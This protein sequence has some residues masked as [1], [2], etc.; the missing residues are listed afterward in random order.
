MSSPQ[1]IDHTHDDLFLQRLSTQLNP[2][3][4]LLI[5]G[6]QISWSALETHFGDLYVSERGHP[7]KPIRLMCGLLMLQHLEG[8]SD[9]AVVS[10]WVEN[11]YWQLFCGY[12]FLQWEMPVDPTSLTRWRHRLGIEGLERILSET[13]RVAVSGGVVQPKDLES[14]IVDTTV[15]EKAVTFPT[16]SK[17]LLRACRWFLFLKSKVS[18]CVRRTRDWVGMLM[19]KPAGMVM[20]V[21]IGAWANK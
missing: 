21:S 9:E 6:R 1:K 12:D 7:P 2:K 8:L 5:L 11:P 17:L 19:G 15:M 3:H 20:R 18:C 4:P 16:D 14:V 13:I 10:K